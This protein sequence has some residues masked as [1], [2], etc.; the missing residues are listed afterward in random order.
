[1]TRDLDPSASGTP[2]LCG[3]MYEW[4]KITLV[5]DTGVRVC[6]CVCVCVWVCVCVCVC[7]CVRACVCA[8]VYM[9]VGVFVNACV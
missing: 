5:Y 1:M 8:F 9:Y 7:A 6:V 2:Q 4:S 3:N